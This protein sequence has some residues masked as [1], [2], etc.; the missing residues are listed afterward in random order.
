MYNHVYT[1][2]YIY[3]DMMAIIVDLHVILYNIESIYN[4]FLPR[5]H[6][7]NR[8]F[9]TALSVK[10]AV[11]W[12]SRFQKA[13]RNNRENY[14]AMKNREQ[15]YRKNSQNTK[16]RANSRAQYLLHDQPPLM[17]SWRRSPIC[18][19]WFCG[20]RELGARARKTERERES[21][22]VANGPR[23]NIHYWPPCERGSER[24]RDA[25]QYCYL[26]FIDVT[27][28]GHRCARS[29]VLVLSYTDRCRRRHRRRFALGH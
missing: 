24:A 5:M 6:K 16:S 2:T 20:A 14:T 11:S 12:H 21:P 1:N 4:F 7:D 9:S 17:R 26:R 28:G 10:L 27:D 23:T 15:N 22:D 25:R 29:F 3:Y 18:A 19:K 13:H 8:S